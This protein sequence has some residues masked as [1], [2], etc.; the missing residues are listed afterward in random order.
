MARRYGPP[1]V[2]G[3]AI[4]LIMAD[5]A[6]EPPIPAGADQYFY[7]GVAEYITHGYWWV[8]P[9]SVTHGST[10]IP[11]SAHPPLF[12]LVLALADLMDLHGVDGQRTFLA[13]LS[14]VAIVC[15]G[16]LAVRL[17]GPRTELTV[18]WAAAVLPGMWIYNG[19]DLSEDITVPLVAVMLL[20]LYRML[21]RPTVPRA[22]LLGAFVA[23][24]ALTRPELLVPVVV[25]MP[26]CFAGRAGWGPSA[27][28]LR[29]APPDRS[30][31]RLGLELTAA[32]LA[33]VVLILGP[34][35]GRNLHDFTRT[36]IV[37]AN[38]GSVL[39]G[40][41]CATTYHGPSIGTWS[42]TCTDDVR[43]PKGDASVSDHYLEV[44]GEHYAEHHAGQ[45]PLVLLARLGRALGV[46]P[47]PSAQV[48][49][50]AIAGGVWPAWSSWVYWVAWWV[51]IPF[52]VVA[53]LALRR[54]QR[55]VWPLYVMI[56]L[57]LANSV[58]LYADPRFASSCQPALAILT[59]TGVALVLQDMFTRSGGAH[60]A[61]DRAVRAPR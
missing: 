36:E 16:R 25:F 56:A 19:Q 2:V 10:G 60:A 6:P 14:L 49:W 44:V 30:S 45:V 29:G 12:S 15:C 51:C 61:R 13:V 57:Y 48:R 46:W 35:I 39:A 22:A 58:L 38:L 40:A 9:G 55:L 37:S 18:A 1:L 26:L 8:D 7:R 20:V 54:R 41:N 21:E 43:V 24:G 32:F 3:L 28:P 27:A 50:N 5:V 53:V 4:R 23:A 52:E 42:A 34:W 47:A 59:G 17:G 33:A 11:A 31:R